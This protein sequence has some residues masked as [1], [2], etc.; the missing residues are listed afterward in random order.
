MGVARL[1]HI[2]FAVLHDEVEKIFP[3]LPDHI[4]SRN[5]PGFVRLYVGNQS[6]SL[7]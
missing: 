3:S 4:K 2:D 1:P 6:W 7:L 5:D